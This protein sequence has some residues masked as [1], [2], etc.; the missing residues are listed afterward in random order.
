MIQ[1]GTSVVAFMVA[2]L[3][4]AACAATPPTTQSPAS[5]APSS[6]AVPAETCGA[7]EPQRFAA[8]AQLEAG[9]T[10]PGLNGD[11]AFAIAGT[12]SAIERGHWECSGVGNGF[13]YEQGERSWRFHVRD[14]ERSAWVGFLLPWD[15]AFVAVG[16]EVSVDFARHSQAW[17]PTNA[18]LTLR[19]KAGELLF[20]AAEAASTQELERPNEVTVTDGPAS[21]LA[22]SSCGTFTRASMTVAL[23]NAQTK[24]A[25]GSIADLGAYTLLHAGNEH[26]VE[27]RGCSDWF[28][29]RSS[30]ALV[31]GNVATLE[32]KDRGRCG[33]A[34]CVDGQYCK[35]SP[36][37]ACS[38]QSTSSVCTAA[39]KQCEASCPGVCG[40]DGKFYCNACWAQRAGVDVNASD[41]T[42]K[43]KGCTGE[44]SGA[45]DFW[46]CQMGWRCFD[47]NYNIECRPVGNGAHCVCSV[48]GQPTTEFDADATIQCGGQPAADQCGFPF[49]SY[50][51]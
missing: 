30:I 43:A 32:A 19:G 1:L 49:M 48:D 51:R 10:G 20:W 36:P 13:Y 41:T 25:Y 37:D 17:G 35:T 44:G 18:H 23:A 39:P 15:S 34:A 22:S 24:L 3:A 14:G 9:A 2:A 29:A 46:S 50:G 45:G 4:T 31:R 6:T 47:L 7:M 28:V 11:G 8:C 26:G 42:C 38:V 33:A 5:N 27:A 12:V 40:C 21:C 16:D